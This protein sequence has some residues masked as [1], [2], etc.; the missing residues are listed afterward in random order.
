MPLLSQLIVLYRINRL[1]YKHSVFIGND[2]EKLQSLTDKKLTC[3]YSTLLIEKSQKIKQL[4][5]SALII[6]YCRLRLKN[7]KLYYKHR[8]VRHNKNFHIH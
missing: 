3:W 6:R 1:I 7:Y 5:V 4:K 8:H 2:K